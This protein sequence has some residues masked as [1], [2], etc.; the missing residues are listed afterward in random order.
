[1]PD[2]PAIEATD[3]HV[4]RRDTHI[5]SGVNCRIERGTCAA[6][7]GPNGSGKTSLTRVVMGHMF[8]TSGSVK[9]LGETMGSTDVRALR[10]RV[11]VV[12][13]SA[14]DS[15]MPGTT[16]TV[17]SELNTLEAAITGYFGTIGLYEK[18]TS[19]QR[20]HAAYML[21]QVGMGHRIDHKFSTLSTGEQRR[22][23]LAR[24]LVRM[25][26][27]LILDEPTAGLDLGGRE[28]V[29]ATVEQIIDRP[30]GPT[31]LLITHHVEELSP[32]TSQVLLMRD[33]QV[34]ACGRPED[35]ITP[36]SLSETFGCKVYVR[37][38]HGRWWLEVLPEAWLDLL[39]RKVQSR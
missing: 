12:N 7:L 5:L 3:L 39:P 16:A 26:E 2:S 38:N 32:R 17:D 34:S 10:Q 11:S 4:V 19:D 15:S 37:R 18:P 21:E 22:C 31:V 28:Q 14:G 36:E 23:L 35:V 27:L 1:M 6:I 8:I 13:P 24:A 9:V 33:G 30:D 25:P 20:D 29:L